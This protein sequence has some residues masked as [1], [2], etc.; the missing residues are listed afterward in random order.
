[1]IL[2]PGQVISVSRWCLLLLLCDRR[3]KDD[4]LTLE[5][6]CYFFGLYNNF[7]SQN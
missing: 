2:Q 6:I 3:E 4:L 1:M 5:P 7:L